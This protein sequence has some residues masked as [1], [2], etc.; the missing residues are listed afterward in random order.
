[1]TVALICAR[2]WFLRTG[3]LSCLPVAVVALSTLAV[4][5]PVAMAQS[6]GRLYDPE[7]PVDSAYV[8]VVAVEAGPALDVLVDD[9][10]RL[11][12]VARFD[13]SDYMVIPEGRHVVSLAPAGQQHALVSHT[14]DVVRGKSLTLAF[15][16]LREPSPPAVF[17]DRGNTNRLKAQITAYNLTGGPGAA[18]SVSTADGANKVFGD[19]AAGASASLQVNPISVD[20]QAAEGKGKPVKFHLEMSA[21]ATYSLLLWRDGKSGLQVRT[22]ANRTERFLGN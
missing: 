16:S 19:L 20:L 7:P 21:G 11:R 8:R 13:A 12:K 10:V 6:T 3:A 18:V 14:L 15:A 5:P 17:E 22:L 4:L 1:M 2:R 9:K